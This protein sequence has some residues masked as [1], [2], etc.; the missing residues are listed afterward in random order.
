MKYLKI[1]LSIVI[2]HV[3]FFIYGFAQNSCINCH[4]QLEDELKTPVDGIKN[5]T[6]HKIDGSC[7]N[8]HGGDPDV[9]FEDDMEAAMDPAKGYVGKPSRKTTLKLCSRCHSNST[10]MRNYNPNLP[11]DQYQQYLTSQHGILLRKGDTKV[12]VCTDCHGVH[13][14]QS[15]KISTSKVFPNNIP[16]T[17]GH[18]H[19]D[20]EYMKDYDIPTDQLDLYKQSVHGVNLF[21][22]GDRSSPTCNSCHGN[23]GA[24]P[25]G[26][27]SISHVCGTCHVTQVEMFA[28]SPHQDAYSEMDL[29]QCESCHGNHDIK[30]TSVEMIGVGSES[31]CI[32]CHDEDSEGY[33]Q[34]KSMKKVQDSLNHKIELAENSLEKAENAGV[35]VSDGLFT[36]KDAHDIL[37]KARNAVHYFSL[38]KYEEVINPGFEIADKALTEGQLA[39][40]EVKNRRV[41][42][43][44]VSIIIFIVAI[45]LYLKIKMIKRG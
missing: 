19:S 37:I 10:Y 42:L 23:H 35:E 16:E 17:C 6:H 45:S 9:K 29:P 7:V 4:S 31:Y 13:S 22:K 2:I 40:K 5:D 32:T 21:E 36:V 30:K 28:N 44:I 27:S 25:P 20:Q 43:A 41:A 12:A 33:E 11:T 38:D 18:C 14:I 8:C 15:A 39:L 26:I 1:F 34:A 3:T 24:F